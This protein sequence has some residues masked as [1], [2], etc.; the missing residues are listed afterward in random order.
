MQ[1]RNKFNKKSD[2]SSKE[3]R[4]IENEQYPIEKEY[5]LLIQRE[6]V[7]GPNLM[8]RNGYPILPTDLQY[9]T[10]CNKLIP[11][12]KY[13]LEKKELKSGIVIKRYTEGINVFIINSNYLEIDSE[14][15]Q[16]GYEFYSNGYTFEEAFHILNE[17]SRKYG[18]STG[19]TIKKKSKMKK[20]LKNQIVINHI[21]GLCHYLE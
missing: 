10:Y 18:Y 11:T 12:K 21:N 2:E 17:V 3:Q 5:I 6:Y 1:W 9:Q 19:V 20:R 15:R 16:I 4:P 7:E 14:S 8:I 13:K